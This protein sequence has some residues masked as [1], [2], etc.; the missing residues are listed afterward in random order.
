MPLT[1]HA[2]MKIIKAAGLGHLEDELITH[3]RDK[4]APTITKLQGDH[5]EV[6]VASVPNVPVKPLVSSLDEVAEELLNCCRGL[7]LYRVRFLFYVSQVLNTFC[8]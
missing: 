5:E 6:A 1:F 7:Q 4:M 8:F 2:C 3:F